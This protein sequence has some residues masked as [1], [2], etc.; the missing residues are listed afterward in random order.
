MEQ[1]QFGQ[2]DGWDCWKVCPEPQALPRGCPSLLT[3][4]KRA[5]HLGKVTLSRTG[6]TG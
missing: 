2:E 1:E 5:E 3:L 4:A 6:I